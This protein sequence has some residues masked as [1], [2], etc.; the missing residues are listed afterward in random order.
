MGAG[1]AS[2]TDVVAWKTRIYD[3]STWAGGNMSRFI[4]IIPSQSFLDRLL[5][6]QVFFVFL[7]DQQIVISTVSYYPFSSAVKKDIRPE[8]SDY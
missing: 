5:S 4:K 6:R 1:W 3:P 7:L 8:I 2:W